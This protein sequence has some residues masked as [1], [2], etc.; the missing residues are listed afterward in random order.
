LFSVIVWLAQ[1]IPAE[2]DVCGD[3]R[4]NPRSPGDAEGETTDRNGQNENCC[5]HVARF[6]RP[7]AS[8]QR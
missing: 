7:R 8:G 4:V 5:S 3:C 6:V 2:S 1:A